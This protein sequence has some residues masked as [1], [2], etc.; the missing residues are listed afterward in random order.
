MKEE[1]NDRVQVKDKWLEAGESKWIYPKEKNLTGFTTNSSHTA[2]RH[3]LQPHMN[4]PPNLG[5]GG[6]Q[7]SSEL[8][9][10]WQDERDPQEL[11]PVQWTAAS[12]GPSWAFQTQLRQALQRDSNP[13]PTV[14]GEHSG[15]HSS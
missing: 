6:S 15:P 8:G 10:P 4:E 5:L 9:L 7:I 1:V 2:P 13:S 3:E 12:R 14:K 11:G